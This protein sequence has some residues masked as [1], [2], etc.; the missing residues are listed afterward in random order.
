MTEDDRPPTEAELR[1]A[2]LLARALEQRA[3]PGRDLRPVGDAL[4]TAWLLRASKDAGVARVPAGGA[5]ER[6]PAGHTWRTR[7]RAVAAAAAVVATVAAFVA[8]HGRGPSPLPAP[9][10]SLLQA[11]LAAAR[12]DAPLAQ[13]DAERA[14]YRRRIFEALG[15][16]Y[17]GE[18]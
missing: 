8:S 4:A 13:V 11:E 9:P 15:H 3:D 16:A 5:L 18:R 1:E 12:P 14:A 6:G 7:A 2:E 10:A 17:G